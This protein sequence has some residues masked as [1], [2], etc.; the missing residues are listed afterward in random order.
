[1]TA[2]KNYKSNH[3]K[4]KLARQDQDDNDKHEEEAGQDNNANKDRKVSQDDSRQL[5]AKMSRN[6]LMILMSSSRFFIFLGKS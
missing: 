6:T 3:H 2:G 1:M 5:Q 4:C